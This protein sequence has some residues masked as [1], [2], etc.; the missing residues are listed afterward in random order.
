MENLYTKTT[1]K[2]FYNSLE[3]KYKYLLKKFTN[4]QKSCFF[5]KHDGSNQ[6]K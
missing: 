6:K 1:K 2:I 5:Q 4:E 3:K